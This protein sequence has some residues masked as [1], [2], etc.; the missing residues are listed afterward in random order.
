M[1]PSPRTAMSIPPIVQWGIGV[2]LSLVLGSM[3]LV[4]NQ[5]MQ[6]QALHNRRL[7]IVEQSGTPAMREKFAV[8]ETELKAMH[9]LVRGIKLD[10]DS[11]MRTPCTAPGRR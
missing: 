2:L 1:T 5:I 6:T 10:L 9:E 4:L 7:E 3:A 11:H 8:L